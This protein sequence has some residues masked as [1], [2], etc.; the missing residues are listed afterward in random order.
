MRECTDGQE[1]FEEAEE[2]TEFLGHLTLAVKGIWICDE[3][4]V[5]NEKCASF[6]CAFGL[7]HKRAVL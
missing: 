7:H 5:L 2:E 1:Q 6:F 3:A 4:G